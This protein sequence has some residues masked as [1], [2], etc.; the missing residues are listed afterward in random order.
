MG[1]FSGSITHNADV[2]LILQVIV[3]IMK[4]YENVELYRDG[5]SRSAG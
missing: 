3:T 4:S 5:G 2:E 1:Y